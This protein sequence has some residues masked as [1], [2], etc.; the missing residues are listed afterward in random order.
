MLMAW[1][2]Q[3]EK[4]AKPAS[5]KTTTG[6]QI[7]VMQKVRPNFVSN[8]RPEQYIGDFPHNDKMVAAH[9]ASMG[10]GTAVMGKGTAKSRVVIAVFDGGEGLC[11]ALSELLGRGFNAGQMAIVSLAPSVERICTELRASEK[12]DV[13]AILDRVEPT[14]LRI[15]RNV[16]VVT[17]NSLWQKVGNLSEAATDEFILARWIDPGLRADLA[18]HIREGAVVLGVSAETSEQQRQCTRVLLQHSSSRVQTHEF[19]HAN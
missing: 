8:A 2:P 17:R 16:V 14:T 4:A 15:G 11:L 6:W 7:V 1:R 18:R 9:S 19:S 5:R 12:P 13:A 10:L 3:Q